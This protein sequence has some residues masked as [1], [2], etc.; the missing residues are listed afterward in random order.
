MQDLVRRFLTEQERWQIE[1][2]VRSAEAGTC[3]EIVVALVSACDPY[4]QAELRGAALLS[5]PP[6]LGLTP[7]L[8]ASLWMGPWN[9]WVFLALALTLFSAALAVVRRWTA[10]RRLLVSSGE[11]LPEVERAAQAAFFRHGLHRTRQA[12]GVLIFIALFERRVHILADRGIDQRLPAGAWQ[13]LVDPLR[14]GIAGGAP[15]AA[16]CSAVAAVGHLLA[17][18]FPAGQENPDELGGLVLDR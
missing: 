4:P 1:A 18:H 11:R 7:L 2:A 17:R 13:A 16:I 15:A 6:A 5:L 9:L 3:G 10:L 8:G 14:E 12:S